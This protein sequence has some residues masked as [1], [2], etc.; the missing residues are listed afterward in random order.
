MQEK[1]LVMLVATCGDFLQVGLDIVLEHVG[2]EERPSLRT[3]IVS[4]VNDIN[5]LSM[6][7]QQRVQGGEDFF[8]DGFDQVVGVVGAHREIHHQLFHPANK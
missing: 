6:F 1:L 8:G 7:L 4:H 5:P 2:T 3:I